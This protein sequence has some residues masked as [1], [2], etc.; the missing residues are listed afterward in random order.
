M[1][2]R[3]A[4]ECAMQCLA[5]DGQQCRAFNVQSTPGGVLC[6]LMT[7]AVDNVYPDAAWDAFVEEVL[8]YKYYDNRNVYCTLL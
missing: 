3:V 2:G 8:L 5:V 1:T 6:E 4:S 7:P